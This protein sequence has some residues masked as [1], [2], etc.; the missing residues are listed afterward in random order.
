MSYKSPNSRGRYFVIRKTPGSASMGGYGAADL[1]NNKAWG[2]GLAVPHGRLT[3]S[4]IF[5][6]IDLTFAKVEVHWHIN[7]IF[8][9]QYVR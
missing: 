7:F 9:I 3:C 8:A 5:Q 1:S 4:R 2:L 6:W